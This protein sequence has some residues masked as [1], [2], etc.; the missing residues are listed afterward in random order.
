[1]KGCGFNLPLDSLSL[2]DRREMRN[3]Q[4]W[5]RLWPIHGYDMIQRP[6][7]QKYLGFTTQEVAAINAATAKRAAVNGT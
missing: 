4:R 6:R 7:W 1:M 5:L 3:F 2:N